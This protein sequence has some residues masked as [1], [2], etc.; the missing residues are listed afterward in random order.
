M[1]IKY[2]VTVTDEYGVEINFIPKLNLQEVDEYAK[3]ECK[4]AKNGDSVFVLFSNTRDSNNS[5]Y[6]NRDGNH[7]P[8][9]EDWN[10]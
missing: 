5:G 6:L 2:T 9:G 4:Q 10:N 8:V 7:S 1:S 3:N